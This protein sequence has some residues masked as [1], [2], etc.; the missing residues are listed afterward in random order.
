MTFLISVA[1]QRAVWLSADR[2]LSQDGV[3]VKDDACKV[4]WL[5]TA[6]GQSI[7]AYTGLGAT[8][9][10]T[11][12]SAWM[13]RVLR[14]RDLPLAESLIALAQAMERS[15][16][17]HLDNS[18]PRHH[19]AVASVLRSSTVLSSIDLHWNG[20]R[21]EVTIGKPEKRVPGQPPIIRFEGS[22][23]RHINSGHRMAI[24]K[25]V[26]D[27]EKGKASDQDVMQVL[28][29]TNEAMAAADTSVSASCI[30]TSR[31]KPGGGSVHFHGLPQREGE[32][33]PS[34]G[35]G[36][37]WG[38][39]IGMVAPEMFKQG[40]GLLGKGPAYEPDIDAIVDRFNRL[41]DGP[42]ETLE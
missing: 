18:L 8:G 28:A 40:I 13:G 41:P 16:P 12:L 22:G 23:S 35:H 3:P 20:S 5:D 25:V 2:Q 19:L 27:H 10:G 1:G 32:H 39:F 21:Y 29:D 4:L 38:T 9:K 15:L 37:D 34:I 33:V 42:D 6:D 24:S 7:L 30:I 36:T 14:G 11:E 31:L 26:R 17:P